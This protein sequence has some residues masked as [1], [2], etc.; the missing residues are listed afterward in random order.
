MK[1]NQYK[2]IQQQ[3]KFEQDLCFTKWL[4]YFQKELTSKEL[5]TRKKDSLKITSIN[6][7]NYQPLQ[8]A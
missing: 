6:N 2:Q 4:D 7:L 8:G 5:N 3:S 1:S